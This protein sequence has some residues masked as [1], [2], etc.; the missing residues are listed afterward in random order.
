MRF[1]ILLA[2]LFALSGCKKSDA[3]KAGSGADSAEST[4]ASTSTSAAN[5]GGLV[6]LK[7]KWPVGNRYV[8]RLEVNGDTETRMPQMPRP[9]AQKINLAQEYSITVVGQQPKS[10]P[11]LQME[12]ESTEMEVTMN[13]KQVVSLD[14]KAEAGAAENDPSIAGF[15][16]IVGAK[17]KFLLDESNRVEKVEGVK[18]FLAKATAA[19]NPQGRATMQGMFSEEYFKQMVDF[20]R[21]LP[22]KPVKVGDS[23][24]LKTDLTV[25]VLG[26]M[27]LD[28]NY[29]LAGWEQREKRKCAVINFVGTMS[30]KGAAG[31]GP[32]GMSMKLE[33]GKLSGKSWFDPELGYPIEA[34]IDQDLVIHMTMAAGRNPNAPSQ[35]QGATQTITNNTK[36]KVVMKLMDVATAGK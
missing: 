14:T 32:M 23:W 13:G 35:Q 31:T 2:A 19:S 1:W 10:G 34:A 5:Q 6:T 28:L 7:M 30:S 25:P 9:M 18:E 17:I 15:R 29:T 27:N 12:F 36:Q 4:S 11:E 24:P 16:Q 3:P 20:Q 21:G 26:Q 22:D 8:Q 33:S